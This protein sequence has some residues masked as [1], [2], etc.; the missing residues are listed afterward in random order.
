GSPV[1]AGTVTLDLGDLAELK[2]AAI[3]RH[4]SQTGSAGAFSDWPVDARDAYLAS[5]SYRL[6]RS[7]LPVPAGVEGTAEAG[8]FDG[9][10]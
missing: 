5:E 7:N 4:V 8:L 10:P 3:D 1:E 6:A 2:L 9:L